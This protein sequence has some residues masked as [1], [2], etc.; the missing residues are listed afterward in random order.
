MWHTHMLA[1]HAWHTHTHRHL[2]P[3]TH[4]CAS[5]P[6]LAQKPAPHAWHTH[7]PPTAQPE[8]GS[9]MDTRTHRHIDTPKDAHTDCTH[10]RAVSHTALLTRGAVT[11]PRGHTA[12]V[13]HT[14]TRT[15][16]G[17]CSCTWALVV[18]PARR[19]CPRGWVEDAGLHGMVHVGHS[20]QGHATLSCMSP[21][22]H[23]HL[24]RCF[25]P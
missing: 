3:G 16:P 9:C 10:E 25:P 7:D 4:T 5:T 17:L 8:R 11:Q 12:A 18:Q 14:H 15:F 21:S 22:L 24:S 6:C 13:S 1:P 2:T 23:P 20:R 19:P